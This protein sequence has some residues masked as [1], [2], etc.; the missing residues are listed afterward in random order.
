MIDESKNRVQ[1]LGDHLVK[2]KHFVEDRFG[3]VNNNFGIMENLP[4]RRLC[5]LFYS[6]FF[7]LP[8]KEY[9]YTHNDIA[10]RMKIRSNKFKV[11][12]ENAFKQPCKLKKQG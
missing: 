12:L 2:P 7:L 4:S 5:D 10:C 8:G 6:L 1:D 3:S 11:S 9:I